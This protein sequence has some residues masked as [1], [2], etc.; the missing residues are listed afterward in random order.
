MLVREGSRGQNG[1]L[2]PLGQNGHIADRSQ[3]WLQIASLED[4]QPF[5]LALAHSQAAR[6]T[7]LLWK[8]TG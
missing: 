4:L 2:T 1:A 5:S 6:T 8:L 3:M 7:I